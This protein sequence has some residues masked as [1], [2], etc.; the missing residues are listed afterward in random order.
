VQDKSGKRTKVKALRPAPR[1]C[2]VGA[3]HQAAVLSACFAD[4]GYEVCGVGD[5]ANA[6][7]KLKAG[8]PPLPEPGLDVI[9]NRNLAPG[10]LRFTLDYREAI[11]DTDFV[12]LSHDTR[13]DDQDCPHLDEVFESA[14][15][16]AAAASRD[17]VVCVTAQVPVGTCERI[18]MLMRDHAPSSRF[19]VVYVPEFLRLGTAIQSFLEPDR[20]L[21]GAD[22]RC[23][24]ERVAQLYA[25]LGC[26]VLIMSVRSAE[27]AKHASNAFLAASISFINEIADLCEEVGADVLDV[28]AGMRLDRRIGPQAFL[29]AGPG[30]AGGTLARDIRVLQR[31]SRDHSRPVP[32]LDGVM[33][34]NSNRSRLV[35]LHLEDCFGSVAGLEVGVLGLTYKPGT[36]T[37]RRSIA[38]DIISDLASSQVRIKAFDPLATLAD[39]GELPPFRFC[40]DAYAAAEG[41][42]ALVMV[43]EWPEFKRL[44]FA[45]IR[46]SM[47]RQVLIDLRNLLDPAGMAKLGFTYYGTGRRFQLASIAAPAK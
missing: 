21:I 28:A 20:I 5:D 30:F 24:A 13:V 31:L 34:T 29:K 7:I 33:V 38:L 16:A 46:N 37:L 15:Q 6:I 41:T 8:S 32:L 40:R 23:V 4:L 22:D 11:A 26:P 19:D 10:H 25:P 35:R 2:V 44:D 18:G 27:M 17:M 36:N 14:K 12:F 1:I 47:R 43:T 39:I 9:L 3:W 45:R 42:D